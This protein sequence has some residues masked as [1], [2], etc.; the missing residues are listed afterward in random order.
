MVRQDETQGTDDVGRDAPEN[1]ALD[2]RLANQAKLVIFEI[3]QAAMHQ[4]GRPGRRPA[5]QIVHFAQEN[6][7]A[8]AHRVTRDAAAVNTASDDGE[9]E[10]TLQQTHPPTATR[11]SSGYFRF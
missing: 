6:R 1:L 5:R 8:A 3:A 2:Q 11:S 9:V 4:L 10:N 7:V